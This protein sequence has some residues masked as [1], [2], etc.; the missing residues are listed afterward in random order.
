ML[1]RLFKALF[2]DTWMLYDL[3]RSASNTGSIVKDLS[4]AHSFRELLHA[5]ADSNKALGLSVDRF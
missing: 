1:Q 3:C 4:E 2:L 5:G